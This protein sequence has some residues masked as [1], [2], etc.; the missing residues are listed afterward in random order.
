MRNINNLKKKILYR[1][2]HRGTKEMDLLL[3][4]FVKKYVN[5]L[6]E[7]ELCELESL[8]NI[9][10]E[11][12]YKWYLNKQTTTSIPINSITKKLKKFKLQN[13]GGKG[14]IRTHE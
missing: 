12:L 4:N 13:Y 2:K 3:S 11:V 5:S 9:D 14:G 8:L 1:S 7:S 6:N 10:D